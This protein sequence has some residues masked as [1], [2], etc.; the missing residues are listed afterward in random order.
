MW[1]RWQPVCWLS[2][3]T[4]RTADWMQCD[5]LASCIYCFATNERA[6]ILTVRQSSRAA[7][8]YACLCLFRED[9]KLSR[10]VVSRRLLHD[11]RP[12]PC[13]YSFPLLYSIRTCRFFELKITHASYANVRRTEW[14]LPPC[15]QSAPYC[16]SKVFKHTLFRWMQYLEQTP[17][18]S[19]FLRTMVAG[20]SKGPQRIH[21]R[22]II[23]LGA[24][25][26]FRTGG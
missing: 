18:G 17:L 5:Q 2:H 1:R 9:D 3:T 7:H 6:R 22:T 25:R 23:R 19:L 13:I 12:R 8:V 4:D 26:V 11:G 20:I 24:A 21:F 16:V 14:A 10:A 15:L